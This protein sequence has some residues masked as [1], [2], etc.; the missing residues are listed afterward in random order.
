MDFVRD[1]LASGG[2]IKVLTIVDDF[3]R[4]VVNLAAR[5]RVYPKAI[6]TYQWPEYLGKEVDQLGYKRI[7]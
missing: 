3:S 6:R 2:W 4:E 7:H 5:L 1:A